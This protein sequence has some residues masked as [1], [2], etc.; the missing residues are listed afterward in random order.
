MKKRLRKKKCI[1]EFAEWG[2]EVMVTLRSAADFDGFLDTFIEQ[3]IEANGCC[4]GGGG[5]GDTLEFIVQL[6]RVSQD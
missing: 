5:K 6:G 4:C 2:R 1:G 3:A